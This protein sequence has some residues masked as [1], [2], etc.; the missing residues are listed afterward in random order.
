MYVLAREIKPYARAE[1]GVFFEVINWLCP[2][3]QSG[4]RGGERRAARALA[5]RVFLSCREPL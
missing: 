4:R 3:W 2:G 1:L 5:P